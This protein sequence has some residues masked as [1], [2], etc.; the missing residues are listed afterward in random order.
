MFMDACFILRSQLVTC[1]PCLLLLASEGGGGGG[2]KLAK[3][4]KQQTG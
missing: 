2:V 3:K 1:M 4:G